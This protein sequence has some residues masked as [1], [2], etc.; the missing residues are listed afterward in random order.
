M[1]K[2]IKK[3]ISLPP[4]VYKMAEMLMERERRTLSNLCEKCIE[5]KYKKLPKA[6]RLPDVVERG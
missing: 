2:R 6:E 3:S 1:D 5:E 4:D